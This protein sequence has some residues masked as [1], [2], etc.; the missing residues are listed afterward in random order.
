MESNFT[1]IF[2]INFFLLW[3]FLFAVGILFFITISKNPINI[4]LLLIGFFLDL[5][6][7]FIFCGADYL[8]ILF[9]ILYAGAISIILLFV[10]MLLDLKDLIL[11]IEKIAKIL[12]YFYIFFLMLFSLKSV[13]LCYHIISNYIPRV[14]YVE[15]LELFYGLTNIKVI[16][17]VLYDYYLFQFIIIGVFL[18]LIMI[19]IISLV[20]NFNMLTKRQI[21][22]EQLNKAALLKL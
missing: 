13:E 11:Q 8:A 4:I 19:I 5:S 1:K 22:S 7:L 17:V 18:F 3:I 12:L 6:L 9:L 2:I 15:W 16:G 14:F 10:V 21:V 20:V